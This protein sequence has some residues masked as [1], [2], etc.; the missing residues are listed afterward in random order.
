MTV[1]S[2]R[3]D[4]GGETGV[5]ED[6]FRINRR[7]H[8]VPAA[9]WRPASGTAPGLVLLGHG[10]GGHKRARRMIDL[11]RWLVTEA[12]LAAV[13][14]DGPFH[15]D[16][17]TEPITPERHQA[18]VAAEGAAAVVDRMVEDWLATIDAVGE[19]G[20]VA[21][22]ALGYFG[23]S[24]GT[25]YGLPLAAALGDRLHTAVLGKFGLNHPGRPA[26][27]DTTEITRAAAQRITAQTM[28]HIQWH[29]QV[30]PRDGQLA[31]F[32]LLACP[33]KRLVAYPGHH[34]DATPD[35][36]A[37]WRDFLARTIIRQP[38]D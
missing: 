8:V 35:A 18:L 15:G 17:H 4:T 7:G 5:V 11:S 24:M 22:D 14:I 3:T 25:R 21:T 6:I 32:D 13:A 19:L 1:H 38:I 26:A 12:G 30:F 23:L 20:V 36:V 9:L 2:V 31:L 10:A 29:D 27:L 37:S 33:D 34:A 28:F 16:R